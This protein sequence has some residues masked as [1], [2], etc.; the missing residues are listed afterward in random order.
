MHRG[1]LHFT[2]AVVHDENV[3]ARLAHTKVERAGL[4]ERRHGQQAVGY[5]FAQ[6]LE[7]GAGHEGQ[8]NLLRSGLHVEGGDHQGG[9]LAQVDLDILPLRGRDMVDL[10]HQF[11]AGGSGQQDEAGKQ[12]HGTGR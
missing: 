3:V 4:A 8:A 2:R 11:D 6:T 1:R 9:I 5:I 10:V 12:V 7:I